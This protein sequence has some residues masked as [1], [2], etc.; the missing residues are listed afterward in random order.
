MQL[1]KIAAAAIVGMIAG[2]TVSLLPHITATM[3]G[4]DGPSTPALHVLFI[5]NSYTFENN[6]PRMFTAL[7]RAGNHPVTT[8]M[9]VVGGATLQQHLG[10]SETR[11]KLAAERW[12]FVVL[13]EQSVIPAI[14]SLR[15]AQMYPAVRQFAQ[16]IRA[17]GAQPVLLLTWGRRDG[18]RDAGYRDYRTMQSQLTDGYMTIADEL[19][20]TVA[21]A[22]VAWQTCAAQDAGQALWQADGSHPSKRGSYLT[23]CIVYA[24][25]FRESPVGLP[26]SNGLSFESARGLQQLAQET[27]LTDPAHWHIN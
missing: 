20:V 24:T 1:Q 10:I 5:G 25:L 3:G 2:F 11:D 26:P 7:A 18:L 17:R 23:A 21:P 27:V 6:L 16:T 22:G 13:Q 4:S 8:G 9:A 14:P 12:D 19:N 15:T